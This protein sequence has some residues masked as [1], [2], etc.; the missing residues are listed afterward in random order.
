MKKL[1]IGLVL[2]FML[3]K[4]L[5]GVYNYYWLKADLECLETIKFNQKEE[6]QCVAEKLGAF[7]TVMNIILAQPRIG[8]DEIVWRH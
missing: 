6:F 5:E 3:H 7:K 1:F 4:G 2:G 8:F